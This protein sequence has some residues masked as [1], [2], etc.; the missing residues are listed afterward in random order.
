[1]TLSAANASDADD[2]GTTTKQSVFNRVQHFIVYMQFAK[3]LHG[4]LV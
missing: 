4:V 3:V 1:M 2:Y